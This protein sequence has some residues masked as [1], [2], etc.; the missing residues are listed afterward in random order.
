MILRLESTGGWRRV[1]NADDGLES[2]SQ[3]LMTSCGQSKSRINKVE[4]LRP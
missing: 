1:T 3:S 4:T 2:L